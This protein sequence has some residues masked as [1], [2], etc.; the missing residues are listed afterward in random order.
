MLEGHSTLVHSVAFSL[1]GEL[2]VY[3]PYYG[4]IRLWD[5]TTGA[6]PQTLDGYHSDSDTVPSVA[7][8][9]YSKQAVS[10]LGD[11]IVRL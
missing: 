9:P 6:V 10:R 2:V 8:L 7:F 11:R 5:V 3:G 1:D 4:T